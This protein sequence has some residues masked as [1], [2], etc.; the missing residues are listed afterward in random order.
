[1]THSEG[2]ARPES[3]HPRDVW[4]VE[5]F[6]R[7]RCNNY[8]SYDYSVGK[9][10]TDSGMDTPTDVRS[11]GA[12]RRGAVERTSDGQLG[13]GRGAALP[14]PSRG[15]AGTIL[16]QKLSQLRF[17]ADLHRAAPD[18]ELPDRAVLE[19][20]GR[21]TS[22]LGTVGDRRWGRPCLK[23]SARSIRMWRSQRAASWLVIQVQASTRRCSGASVDM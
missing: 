23:L 1:M 6:L 12:S 14:D 8:G 13:S 3:L 5:L 18:P 21:A 20:L 4:E 7:G 9:C 22:R 19:V 16:M 10:G 2:L 17:R 11:Q 15:A